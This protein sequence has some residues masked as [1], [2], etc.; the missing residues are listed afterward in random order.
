MGVM[1]FIA[2]WADRAE[3]ADLADVT[4]WADVAPCMN[5]LFYFGCFENRNRLLRISIVLLCFPSF[6][7]LVSRVDEDLFVQ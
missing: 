3:G 6:S 5:T 1:A 4:T 2:D 7:H